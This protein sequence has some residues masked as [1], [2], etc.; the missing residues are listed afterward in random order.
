VEKALPLYAGIEAGH[1]EGAV[2]VRSHDVHLPDGQRSSGGGYLEDV[3]VRSNPGKVVLHVGVG[4]DAGVAGETA[5]EAAGQYL[6]E[7][8]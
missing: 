6:V 3:G 2:C 4:L 7:E 5:V 1:A 8:E